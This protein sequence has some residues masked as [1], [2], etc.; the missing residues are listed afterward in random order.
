LLVIRSRYFFI[1]GTGHSL[2]I[3]RR[4]LYFIRVAVLI[5]LRVR[6][7][8]VMH[9]HG[10]MMNRDGFVMNVYSVVVH[11][12][13]IV[14]DDDRVVVNVNTFVMLDNGRYIHID[15]LVMDGL[16]HRRMMN[17]RIGNGRVP[18][19]LGPRRPAVGKSDEKRNEHTCTRENA[20]EPK[21]LWQKLG[22]D[23]HISRSGG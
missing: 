5:I 22:T 8:V 7:G 9:V 1:I 18:D 23:L 15:G 2:V 4:V 11:V 14:V 19:F 13:G 20:A 17:R 3:G 10:F 6:N 21:Q 12:N 16:G